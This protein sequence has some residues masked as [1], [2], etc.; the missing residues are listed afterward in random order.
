MKGYLKLKNINSYFPNKLVVGLLV[1]S[2]KCGHAYLGPIRFKHIC[3]CGIE[4]KTLY[5]LEY[6]KKNISLFSKKDIYDKT[7]CYQGNKDESIEW[8]DDISYEDLVNGKVDCIGNINEINI[9]LAVCSKKC[10]NYHLIWDGAPQTCPRCGE[11]M[12]RVKVKKYK[13]CK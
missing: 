8:I 7:P 11:Q 4:F 9:A 3:D 2:K 13:L 12:Y 10:G 5:N 6:K 1:C